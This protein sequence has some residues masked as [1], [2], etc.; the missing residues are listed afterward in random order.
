MIGIGLSCVPIVYSRS[1]AS[2]E[3]AQSKEANATHGRA[4]VRDRKLDLTKIH[5]ID[6]YPE[7]C[8]LGHR[9]QL[10]NSNPAD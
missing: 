8:Q 2:D 6:G 9:I 7:D 1:L 3:M 4:L 5:D 10:P